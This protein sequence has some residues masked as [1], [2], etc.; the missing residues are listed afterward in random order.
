MAKE[1]EES[2]Q[3]A[4]DGSGTPGDNAVPP[5][6]PGNLQPAETGPTA[7]AAS[8][9]ADST[10]AVPPDAAKQESGR[11]VP[12][13][14]DTSLPADGAPAQPASEST[15]DPAHEH[16]NP[17]EWRDPAYDE[18]HQH[19]DPHHYDHHHDPHHDS[20][21]HGHEH[22]P[23][24]DYYH[25]PGAYEPS[26]SA[27]AGG[28][29]EEKTFEGLF[30][31]GGDDEE[32]GPIKGFLEHLEDL[33]WVLI[34]CI[35]AVLIAMVTCLVAAPLLIKFLT[36]PL[37]N[38]LFLPEDNRQFVQIQFG[39]NYWNLPV[40]TNLSQTLN[41]GTNH[42]TALQIAPVVIG[43]N[44]LLALAP[45]PAPIPDSEPFGPQL[46][47][48]DPKEVVMLTLKIALYGGLGIASPFV[49]FFL[50]Q[51]IVPALKKKE[52]QYVSKGLGV[53]IGLFL[54]G[55]AF[56]YFILLRVAYYFLIEFCAWLGFAADE[57]RASEFITFTLI[58]MV[59]LGVAFELPVVLLT[60]V[61]IGILDHE[62]LAKLR[63]YFFILNLVASAFITPTGDPVTMLL[64]AAPLQGLYE[65]SVW[66]ARYW[67]WQDRKREAREA[68]GE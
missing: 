60:L 32:G 65:I 44:T 16:H 27:S 37:R 21:S 59:G 53:G 58:F 55:A 62:R 47:I 8:K 19:D 52:R 67:A 42:L 43:T 63:P 23:H 29:E 13:S 30:G 64:V 35:A 22:E 20:G 1:P 49:F 61:K 26:G 54:A 3:P 15:S 34:K 33:R 12:S 66:I 41:L 39:T 50:G 6:P 5:A 18:Y 31:G 51:F 2:G 40:T 38:P 28:K 7:D 11:G 57:W 46:K 36:W 45:A 25:E 4:S 17:E 10:P 14:T 9:P 24:G 56:A 68:A 48:Y